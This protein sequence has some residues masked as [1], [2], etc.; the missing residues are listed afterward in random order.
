MLYILFWT[1]TPPPAFLTIESSVASQQTPLARASASGPEWS[2]RHT[3]TLRSLAHRHAGMEVSWGFL[4]G[5]LMIRLVSS[6]YH[7]YHPFIDTVG[8]SIMNHPAIPRVPPHLWKPP[9]HEIMRVFLYWWI[10]TGY[11]SGLTW[12]DWTSHF[13]VHWKPVIFEATAVL[14]SLTKLAQHIVLLF[15]HI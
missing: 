10:N 5:D 13:G 6:S 1:L 8:F 2:L 9:S 3:D 7:W 4:R 14:M 15:C 11:C 12:F